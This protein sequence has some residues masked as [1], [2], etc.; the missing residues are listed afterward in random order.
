MQGHYYHDDAVAVTVPGASTRWFEV[1]IQPLKDMEGVMGLVVLSMEVTERRVRKRAPTETERRLLA[2]TEHARDII[3]VAGHDGMRR[4]VSG[5]LRNS[6]GYAAEERR[7]TSIFEHIH[8][9]DVE[10]VRAK[11]K[12]LINGEITRFSHQ[13]RARHKDGSYR[14]LQSD[15]KSAFGNPFIRGVVVSSRDITERKQTEY[16]LARR[17]EVFRLAADAVNG[18]IFE[19]DLARGVVHRSRGVQ[20]VLGMAPDDL[21]AAGAWA[22]RIHPQDDPGY[23]HKISAALQSGSG[24]TTTYRIR[25]AR[26]SYR[27]MLERGLIQRGA[28]GNAVRAIGC[29]VDVSE[30]KRLT[31]L[32]TET[33]RAAQ[34]GGWEYSYP[35]R[36]LTWT[37]EMFH[38]YETNPRDFVVSWESML[39]QCTPESRQRFNDACAAAETA[40]GGFDLEL[41]ITTLCN[42]RLWVRIVGHVEKLDGRPFRAFGSVQNIQSQKLAQIALNNSTGWLKLSMN[43]AHMHAWRWDLATDM[44]EFAVVDEQMPHLPRMFPG[45]KHLIARVHPKDRLTVWRAIDHAFES[46]SEVQAEF[47]LRT[48]SGSYRSFAAV[49]RPLFDA[50]KP[51][52]RF[53]GRDAGC[54]RAP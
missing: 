14:W 45:M 54:H 35:T 19:W 42:R 25:D 39:V 49:A 36:E 8:P 30:I 18:I 11:Y 9:D 38:I 10:P 26:G 16:Q 17:E 5:G 37:D 6:L 23:N 20:E 13:F 44:L 48:R 41:E 15:Y 40:D 31:D 1:D 34:M 50:A 12:Q 7:A 52:E 32:L 51:A 46:Q 28:D 33:Q 24:W 21:S 22:A 3:T 47:R 27:S 29:C 53:G 4:L 43:M 2:L